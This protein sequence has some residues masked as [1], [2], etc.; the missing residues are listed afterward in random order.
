MWH[1]YQKHLGF[2]HEGLKV[3]P[4]LSHH[5]GV[6][7]NSSINPLANNCQINPICIEYSIAPKIELD[8]VFASLNVGEIRGLDLAKQL[9]FDEFAVIHRCFHF[10]MFLIAPLK[11]LTMYLTSL[12]KFLNLMVG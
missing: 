1:F 3:I 12:V 11:I 7:N 4:I 9:G 10:V 2:F 6:N 8:N 5:E